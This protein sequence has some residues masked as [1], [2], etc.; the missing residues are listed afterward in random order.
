[1]PRISNNFSVKSSNS[2]IF[3]QIDG[4]NYN[5][6]HSA[7]WKSCQKH[8]HYFCGKIIIFSVKSTFLLKNLLKSWFTEI[9]EMIV[10][11]SAFPLC[12]PISNLSWNCKVPLSCFMQNYVN[13]RKKLFCWFCIKYQRFDEKNYSFLQSFL[14]NWMLQ[15]FYNWKGFA[16]SMIWFGGKKVKYLVKEISSL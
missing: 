7:V 3:R 16:Q 6:A 5:S 12:V 8:D 1:M 4:K 9:F 2:Y 14:F 10:F 15:R 11:Y 13:W